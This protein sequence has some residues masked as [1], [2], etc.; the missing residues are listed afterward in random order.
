M[1]QKQPQDPTAHEIIMLSPLYHISVHYPQGS[2]YADV[3][4][5]INAGHEDLLVQL[6]PLRRKALNTSPPDEITSDT[7]SIA[8]GSTAG[9]TRKDSGC[10][11]QEPKLAVRHSQYGL[12]NCPEGTSP[13]KWLTA[14]ESLFTAHSLCQTHYTKFSVA[15]GKIVKYIRAEAPKLDLDPLRRLLDELLEKNKA[16]PGPMDAPSCGICSASPYT[17]LFFSM[18]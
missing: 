17:R 18:L 7:A 13:L 2:L 4:L 1:S 10:H 8:S 15:A 9:L 12:F 3:W 16:D 5:G 6:T 11:Q 14:K